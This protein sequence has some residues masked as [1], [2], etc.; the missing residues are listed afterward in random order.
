MIEHIIKNKDHRD[1]KQLEIK[2][3]NKNIR[4]KIHLKTEIPNTP[5]SQSLLARN[6]PV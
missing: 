5:N 4:P 3:S 1:D 6:D 2:E